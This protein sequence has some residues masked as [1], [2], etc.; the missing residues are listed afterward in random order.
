MTNWIGL[1]FAEK[2]GRRHSVCLVAGPKTDLLASEKFLYSSRAN[3]GVVHLLRGARILQP[4]FDPCFLIESAERASFS[5]ATGSL[6]PSVG[7]RIFLR[8]TSTPLHLEGPVPLGDAVRIG[9]EF[10]RITFRLD[11]FIE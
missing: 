8:Y 3:V 2:T 1:H 11:L 4:S 7:F 5:F 9:T 6:K 10:V